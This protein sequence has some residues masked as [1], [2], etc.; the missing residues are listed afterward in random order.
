[1]TTIPLDDQFYVRYGEEWS[2]PLRAAHEEV[3]SLEKVENWQQIIPN[4]LQVRRFIDFGCGNG[5]FLHHFAAVSGS[6]GVGIDLS[7][8]MLE[9]ARRRFP[10]HHFVEGDIGI[11]SELNVEPDVI[12][13]NDVIEHVTDPKRHLEMAGTVSPYVGVRVPLEK[14]WA[15]RMLNAL[16]LKPPVSRMYESDGHLYEWSLD[17][18]HSLFHASGLEVVC[19]F[20]TND[21]ARI[22]FHPYIQ[23]SMKS[24]SGLLGRSRFW[25]YRLMDRLPYRLTQ[26]VLRPLKGST[27]V[28]L[29]RS[30]RK[31]VPNP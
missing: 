24:K 5:V 20:V 14:T 27:L 19:E 28:A 6:T 9:A 21:S 30:Q 15:V 10:M 12:F 2:K 7:T 8:T 13:F 11:L 3:C 31:F 18:V 4:D 16:K 23:E 1:M 22:V 29:C 25:A 26:T 17:D